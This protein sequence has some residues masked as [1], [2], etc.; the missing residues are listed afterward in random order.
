MLKTLYNI[1]NLKFSSRVIDDYHKRISVRL[2]NLLFAAACQFGIGNKKH[3]LSKEGNLNNA[4]KYIVSL[5]TFP[6]RINV[7]WLT[8]ESILRQSSKPDAI[9][10]WLAKSEFDGKESL[11][12]NLLK[13]EERG[14]QIQF[15][16]E[17]LKPHKKYYYTLKRY[18][19][20]NIITVDDDMIYPSSLLGH[21]KR[22]HKKY[23]KSI[24]S[25]LTRKIN[26]K[27]NEIQPY[28]SWGIHK[29]E[30]KR[31]RIFLQIGV[32]GVLY[33][34]DS[35]HSEVLNKEVL[36]Q[37]AL[38]ADDLWLKIMAL[39]KNTPIVSLGHLYPRTFLP[40]IIKDNKQLMDS[41]IGEGRNDKIFNKLLDH[42]SLRGKV[43]KIAENDSQ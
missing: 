35:L 33:P 22:H 29:N 2:S 3:K 34:P 8:V 38:K 24:C 27:D 43:L 6:K 39:K 5:T 4:D 10:L 32:G 23:P 41:N 26:V 30:D 25:I 37:K 17:D 13:L 42:Y 7:V 36:K 21:L 9:I 1:Y 18:P 19:K 31:S 15:C 28:T 20:A 16:D 40:I 14:L 12:Q 11:P